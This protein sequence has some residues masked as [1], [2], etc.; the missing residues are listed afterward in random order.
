MS[1]QSTRDQISLFQKTLASAKAKLVEQNDRL[2]R[3]SEPPFAF[4]IVICVSPLD[5]NIQAF[6]KG[7]IVRI[8]RGS[9][10]G[11][12][13]VIVQGLDREGDVLV[14]SD[15]GNSSWYHVSGGNPAV[16]LVGGAFG[17]ATIVID[18]KFMVVNLP[19]EIA[20]RPGD[21]VK[22]SIESMQIVSKSDETLGGSI[23]Y[24]RNV[25]DSTYSEVDIASSTQV[26]F[27]G[28]F[29]GQLE[30]GDR[31]VIDSTGTIIINNLGKTDERF[32]FDGTSHVRW[33]DIGGLE[34]AKQSMIEAV[35]LPHRNPDVF[36]RYGKKP[37]KGILLYGPP[38]CGK[39]MLAKATAHS[40]AQTYAGKNAHSGFIY[41]KGPEILDRY[42]GV[43]EATI[44]QIFDRARTH[45]YEH[46]YPA[47]IFIDE[48]DA[49]LSK[50][51]TGISSD[52]ERT[53]VPMFL[54]EMDGLE[55]S[56]A[57]I[58]LATNRSD[59]LDPAIV[60][61]GRIDR[62]IRVTRPTPQ[63]A[64]E[65]FNL[66]LAGVPLMNGYTHDDIAQH[67][68]REIFS[69]ERVLY[70]VE[71]RNNGPIDFT[72]GDLINGGMV[73]SAVDQ[74]TSIAL[75]RDLASGGQSGISMADMVA[76][77]DAIQDQNLD[78]N[79]K[80]ELSEFT[81]GLR[82]EIVGVYRVRQDHN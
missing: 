22:V 10:A 23:S 55:D 41:I 37:I 24:I 30:K 82:D 19:K 49:I 57:L 64:A 3:L 69:K 28:R 65:I 63:S 59:I 81:R 66:N 45:R 70:R 21:T 62:K 7:K 32:S 26:V 75:H 2:K 76:A 14:E 8:N 53:I 73:V 80:D 52:I 58:I 33:D 77:I 36:R 25:I 44:R 72:L 16:E 40:L 4:G 9:D 56:S 20:I 54:A 18:G 50:R 43:A 51:G 68:T 31:V 71:T 39:T 48:A 46:G 47:V 78:L 11:L 74:A 5:T 15:L 1:T 27:N 60:R 12:N 67:G 13:G 38:G 42:V 35:E 6:K 17:T 29:S 34:E 61:D 79:H